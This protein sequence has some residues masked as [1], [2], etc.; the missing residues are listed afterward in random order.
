MAVKQSA[1]QSQQQQQQQ[2]RKRRALGDVS[3][4]LLA[5]QQQQQVRSDIKS[6][7]VAVFQPCLEC[8]GSKTNSS[9]QTIIH[10][11]GD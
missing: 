7:R 6:L 3:N 10:C 2:T 11:Y 1:S 8:G 9:Y 5:N 4:K